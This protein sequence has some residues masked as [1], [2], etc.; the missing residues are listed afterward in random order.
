VLF[1]YRRSAVRDGALI[2]VEQLFLSPDGATACREHIQ[3]R[4][5]QLVSYATEDL[6]AEARGVITIDADPKKPRKERVLL[7]QVQGRDSGAKTIRGVEN[8]QTNMLI[9]DTIYPF[10][11]AHWDEILHG[12]A[13]K[14]RLISLDPPTTFGFK[15]VK[16]SETTWRGRPV[17]VVK[18]E[19]ANLILSHLVH[20]IFFSIELAAPHR[21]FS[22][23]GRI[24]PRDKVGG[25]WKFVEAEAVFDWK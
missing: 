22:Y 25:A 17:L 2:Q 10:I 11:L 21:V 18:M 1:Q 3:Y 14:F 9:C 23:T 15:V 4:N 8:Y 24:T 7:E 19:P 16:Q 5:G 20:P 13:V 12:T 6:R